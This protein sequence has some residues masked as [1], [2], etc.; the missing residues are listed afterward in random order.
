MYFRA[1]NSLSKKNEGL[2]LR[3][4]RNVI[5]IH[6]TAIYNYFQCTHNDQKPKIFTKFLDS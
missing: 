6:K 2:Q 1:Q 4:L 3:L 5:I